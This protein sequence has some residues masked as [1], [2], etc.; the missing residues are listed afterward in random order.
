MLVSAMPPCGVAYTRCPSGKPTT[1][2]DSVALTPTTA[3]PWLARSSASALY[4]AIE[5]PRPGIKTT[6]GGFVFWSAAFAIA[7][8]RTALL[9]W[10]RTPAGPLTLFAASAQVFGRYG[11]FAAAFPFAV[12]YQIHTEISS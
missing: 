1:C 9:S 10:K 8:V 6:T 2:E 11:A 3:Y 4:S 12:G 5:L 7:L